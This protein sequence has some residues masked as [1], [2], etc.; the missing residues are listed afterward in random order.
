MRKTTS[1]VE[2]LTEDENE[3]LTLDISFCRENNKNSGLQTLP[4][5]PIKLA[6]QTINKNDNSV[7]KEIVVDLS[8]TSLFEVR[9]AI[10][11]VLG[12]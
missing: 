1:Y 6:I 9:D 4:S 7:M 10:H 2:I 12:H 3:I 11:V 5:S 8:T